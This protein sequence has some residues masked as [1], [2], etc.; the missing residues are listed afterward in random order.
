MRKQPDRRRCARAQAE[1]QTSSAHRRG[2]RSSQVAAAARIGAPRQRVETQ[3]SAEAVDRMA[4]RRKR[5]AGSGTPPARQE[6][7]ALRAN[8]Q[9]EE[10]SACGRRSRA[11]AGRSG[12][13]AGRRAARTAPA[14]CAQHWTKPQIIQLAQETHQQGAM[15][16]EVD[17]SAGIGAVAK[18]QQ[19]RQRR[20][21]GPG[22]HGRVCVGE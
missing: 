7:R 13:I 6:G 15:V 22:G 9:L 10:P 21:E 20:D 5:S 2:G 4:G 1:P 11:G 14:S 3:G 8:S 16:A 18:Q 12:A 17:V 19:Q